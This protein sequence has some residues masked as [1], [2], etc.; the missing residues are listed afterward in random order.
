VDADGCQVAVL[1]SSKEAWG[2]MDDDQFLQGDAALMATVPDLFKA[3]DKVAAVSLFEP[4]NP[5]D[6]L[7]AYR[8][9]AVG[10]QEALAAARK[11]VVT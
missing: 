10:A 3:C 8:R 2:G 4:S 1:D 9:A 7:I 6:A 5:T 11:A